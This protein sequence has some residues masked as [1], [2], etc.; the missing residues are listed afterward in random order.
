M[1]KKVSVA[2]ALKEKNRL[3]DI[4]QGNGVF[5]NKGERFMHM[6]RIIY[7]GVLAFMMS[8]SA[9]GQWAQSYY[10]QNDPQQVFAAYESW[11]QNANYQFTARTS[12]LP[13]IMQLQCA[14]NVIEG[15]LSQ[16]GG[17]LQQYYPLVYAGRCNVLQQ[18][19]RLYAQMATAASAG[20]SSGNATIIDQR[21]IACKGMGWCCRC[22]GSGLSQAPKYTGVSGN[23]DDTCRMCNGTG[24]CHRCNRYEIRKLR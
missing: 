17:F 2:R 16:W 9:F 19:R 10:S 6:L 5:Q 3:V 14:I 7:I 24:R 13:P 23:T 8:T 21:C 11:L 18:Y 1:R 4:P 22:K 20:I 15:E 12:G